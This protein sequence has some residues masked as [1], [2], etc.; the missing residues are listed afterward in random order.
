M[1]EAVEYPTSSCSA[2]GSR[3]P[4]LLLGSLPESVMEEE[5]EADEDSARLSKYS[6]HLMSLLPR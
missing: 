4:A 1:A 3:S 5:G 6:K 2:S